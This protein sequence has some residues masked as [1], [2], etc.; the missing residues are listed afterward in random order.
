MVREHLQKQKQKQKK[1]KM[2]REMLE[3][4]YE[5]QISNKI[6]NRRVKRNN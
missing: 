5:I 1:I 3:K 6:R 2:I 4:T